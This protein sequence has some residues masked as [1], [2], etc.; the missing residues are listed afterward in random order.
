MNTTKSSRSFVMQV[1]SSQINEDS[2]SEYRLVLSTQG[3]GQLQCLT[4]NPASGKV[5]RE[6]TATRRTKYV[7]YYEETD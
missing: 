5:S 1:K 4:R 2:Y 3:R 7:V 6:F